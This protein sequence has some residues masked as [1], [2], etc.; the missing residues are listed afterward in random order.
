MPTRFTFR[1]RR[2]LFNINARIRTPQEIALSDI[3]VAQQSVQLQDLERESKNREQ[4]EAGQKAI[5]GMGLNPEQQG[6]ALTE[7]QKSIY[8][9]QA[10]QSEQ[11]RASTVDKMTLGTDITTPEMQRALE[12]WGPAAIQQGS[13]NA[14][15]QIRKAV[16][17][18]NLRYGLVGRGATRPQ[19]RALAAQR[20]GKVFDYIMANPNIPAEEK[21]GLDVQSMTHSTRRMLLKHSKGAG[22]QNLGKDIIFLGSGGD[23]GISTVEEERI[24]GMIT[25]REAADVSTVQGIITDMRRN[26]DTVIDEYRQQINE[27]DLK[28]LPGWIL[29]SKQED[30]K[31]FFEDSPREAE[32]MRRNRPDVWQ[33]LREMYLF[34]TGRYE[35]AAKMQL[36]RRKSV[37]GERGGLPVGDIRPRT[38]PQNEQRVI[39]NILY[40]KRNGQWFK[41]E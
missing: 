1:P 9:E 7:L 39:N 24:P 40:E 5:M 6:L 16:K 34:Y 29:S 38:Q 19:M 13:E 10:L 21:I 27:L 32:E 8:P 25:G 14:M 20:V 31:D 2:P 33:V 28:E 36:Q 26:R 17:Q 22:I 23:L 12:N 11:I 18:N 37:T 3:Q 41:V 30:V 4:F 35:Q 15:S